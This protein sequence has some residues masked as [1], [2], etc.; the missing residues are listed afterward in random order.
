MAT[1]NKVILMGNLTRDPEL[2]YTPGGA[3]I[4]KFSVALNEKYKKQSGEQVEKVHYIDVTAWAK[5]GEMIAQYFKKGNPILLEGKLQ[6]DRWEDKNG[7]GNRSKV[8]VTAERF[9]FVGSKSQ[10]AQ[11]GG[12]AQD[13]SVGSGAP[14]GEDDIPF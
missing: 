9:S 5:T 7:G 14:V 4:C 10:G 2:T 1:F 6:Q 3:P 8:S 11:D 12:G 13:A